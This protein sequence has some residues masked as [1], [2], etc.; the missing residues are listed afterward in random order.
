MVS[1]H[2]PRNL[3]ASYPDASGVSVGENMD[4]EKRGEEQLPADFMAQ[5][6]SHIVALGSGNDKASQEGAYRLWM[7]AVSKVSARLTR[8]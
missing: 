4:K 5:V 1:N 2:E 3:G 8:V 6:E 7:L